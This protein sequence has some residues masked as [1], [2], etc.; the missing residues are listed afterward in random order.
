MRAKQAKITPA[1]RFDRLTP[2]YDPIVR[3]TTRERLF[4]SMLVDAAAIERGDYV[5][6]VGCGTGT[7][8]QVIADKESAV[9]LTGLDADAG[10]LAIAD[11]K[12]AAA[13]TACNLVLGRSTD[14][15]FDDDTFDR[16][17]STLFFHHLVTADKQATVAEI[18]R[19]LKPGGAAHVADWGRPTGPIQRLAFYQIQL[20]DGFVSTRGHVTGELTSLFCE[21]GFQSVEEV[22]HL[23][24]VFGTL[25]F[26]RAI[27]RTE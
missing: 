15:G 10:I 7:L 18:A 16:V 19:V 5:L 6:D 14:M 13:G 24:T 20:L 1:L 26:I 21:A 3:Y 11:R 23:L 12:L 4:K 25:R 2:L 27:K 22:T 9:Q 17:V 8:L